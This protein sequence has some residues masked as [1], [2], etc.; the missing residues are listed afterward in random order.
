MRQKFLRLSTFLRISLLN[1]MRLREELHPEFNAPPENS[2]S[3]R[4]HVSVG[5]KA[6]HPVDRMALVFGG[7][8]VITGDKMRFASDQASVHASNAAVKTVRR[9]LRPHDEI[10]TRGMAKTFGAS[11]AG[12]AAWWS[13]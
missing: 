4:P 9:R 10:G 6:L 11:S 13:G 8:I 3:R 7:F 12:P 5:I 2:S 1:S